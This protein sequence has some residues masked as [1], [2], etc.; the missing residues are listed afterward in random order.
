MNLENINLVELNAQEVQE[1]EGGWI[2]PVALAALYLWG[3]IYKSSNGMD[4]Y[5]RP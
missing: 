1:V 5:G 4:E 2:V 3:E